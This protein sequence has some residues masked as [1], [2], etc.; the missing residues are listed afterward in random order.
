M[1][2]KKEQHE[3][4]TNNATKKKRTTLV[5]CSFVFPCCSLFFRV[6][7]F[8]PC[9]SFCVVSLVFCGVT[10]FLW[11]HSFF[12][13]SFVFCG[14]IRFSVQCGGFSRSSFC[15]MRTHSGFP[16][17]QR[18]RYVKFPVVTFTTRLHTNTASRGEPNLFNSSMPS[19]S[20]FFE[21]VTSTSTLPESL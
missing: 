2:R 16:N 19:R 21:S 13:V 10:R 17:L 6:L 5:F 4:K 15:I 9:S 12:V 18:A 7:R 20:S 11:C 14:V 1:R 8:F 3:E